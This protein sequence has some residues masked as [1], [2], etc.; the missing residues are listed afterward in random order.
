M[1]ENYECSKAVLNF[2][3]NITPDWTYTVSELETKFSV[4]Q[5]MM[6]GG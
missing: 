3:R 1:A 2:N 6:E 4:Q 5:W